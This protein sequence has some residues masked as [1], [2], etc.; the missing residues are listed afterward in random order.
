MKEVNIERKDA[1]DKSALDLALET[2]QKYQAGVEELQADEGLQFFRNLAG[3]RPLH[4]L[5]QKWLSL[6]QLCTIGPRRMSAETTHCTVPVGFGKRIYR[7]CF[8]KGGSMLLGVSPSSLFA[9]VELV[10]AA[11]EDR[12]TLN[13]HRCVDN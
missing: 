11:F 10:R 1:Q 13:V 7:G 4:V 9:A 6:I 8:S 3:Y 5:V 2:N 12:S